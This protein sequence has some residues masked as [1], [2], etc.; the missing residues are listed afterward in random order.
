MGEEKKKEIIS[1]ISDYSQNNIKVLGFIQS[2][3]QSSL[4]CVLSGN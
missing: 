2:D 4:K 3:L 1:Q